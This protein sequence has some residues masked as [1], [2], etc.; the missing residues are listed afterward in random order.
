MTMRL[1]SPS[2]GF[3][4]CL[5]IAGC[6]AHEDISIDG[7]ADPAGSPSGWEQFLAASTH[8]TDSGETFWT[9][10]GDIPVNDIETLRALYDEMA[11]GEV[12]KSL[13]RS[14]GGDDTVWHGEQLNLTYCVATTWPASSNNFFTRCAFSETGAQRRA[15]AIS[16][17]AAAARAWSDVANVY[18]KYVPSEDGNCAPD[19]DGVQ[20]NITPI[21]SA[22]GGLPACAF[23]PDGATACLGHARTMHFDYHQQCSNAERAATYIHEL[24]H[25]LGLAHEHLGSGDSDANGKVD[26][27]NTGAQCDYNAN[28]RRL[29]GTSTYDDDSIMGYAPCNMT[30]GTAPSRLDG[31]GLREL[32]GAPAAWHAAY[33]DPLY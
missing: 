27:A 18:F 14:T 13:V 21:T 33:F 1:Q 8:T 2:L 20:I 26:V 5:W 10:E 9:V 16:Q 4:A 15:L 12:S 7:A 23:F 30:P 32:Y 19:Y 31:M 22:V 29:S 25:I 3:A 11:T 17:M 6:Q 28:W 24:G